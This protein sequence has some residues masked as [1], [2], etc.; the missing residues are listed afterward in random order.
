[1]TADKS[2]EMVAFKGK[3]IR[4]VIHENEWWFS[5]SDVVQTLS[6]SVDVKQYF[7]G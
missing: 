1:M 5:V 6:D 7:K 3:E 2:I 4:R